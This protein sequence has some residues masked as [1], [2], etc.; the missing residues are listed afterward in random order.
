MARQEG[1]GRTERG[2]RISVRALVGFSTVCL[3]SFIAICGSVLWEMRR[4]DEA[5]ARE[6]ME[7]LA[8]TID[9]DIG[10]NIELYD[11]SLRNAATH[12]FDPE[13]NGL[14]EAGQRKMLFDNSATARHFGAMTVLDSN[15]NL[16][17][18]SEIS[19]PSS[20]NRADED[21]FQV[22]RDNADAGLFIGRPRLYRGS[23]ALVLSRRISS[24]DGGFLGVV[25]GSIR[26]SYFH[27]MFG[28]LRL[29]PGDTITVLRRDGVVIMRTP[30]DLDYIGRDLSLTPTARMTLTQPGGSFTGVSPID[31]L[32]R[33]YLWRDSGQPLRV[34][35]AKSWTDLLAIW[36][37]EVLTI[38]S[39][40]LLMIG[41]I[42]AGTTVL[43][44]EMRSRL[45][46]EAQL[47]QMATT[48]ALTGLDNRRKSDIALA[49][50]WRRAQRQGEPLA[51]LMIDA[52]HFKA[53]N[54]ML[55][56]RA[57]DQVLMTGAAS[58]KASARRAGDCAARYGGEEFVLLLPGLTI[59]KAMSVADAIR[60]R[61]EVACA[62]NSGA[63]VSIGVSGV[64]PAGAVTP[65]QLVEAADKAL[66]EAKSRGRNRCCVAAVQ[67]Q[68]RA[69]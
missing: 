60:E 37:R 54:D 56:H 67:S 12:F 16:V 65:V 63:T 25:V 69:A 59:E 53:F 43:A 6:S 41:L 23:Y 17:L 13:L 68:R 62:D 49:R 45:A 48:D 14:A 5:L 58:I 50:E 57:G 2:R 55:G 18:D 35:V 42:I 36:Y 24:K 15:G 52:D 11:L 61:V 1:E 10:R 46:A 8:T 4:A 9:A 40:M 19:R 20:G 3:L 38:G 32:T 39:M 64:T 44:R 27:D 30:F 34:L 51:L 28:R 21:F 31:G 26:F 29:A 33:L 7:N 22:H 66:Y 47:E